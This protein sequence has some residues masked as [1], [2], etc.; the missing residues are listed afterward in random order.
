VSGKDITVHAGITLDHVTGEATCRGAYDPDAF[1]GRKRDNEEWKQRFFLV[2]N[3]HLDSATL[4][5]KEKFQDITVSQFFAT[6]GDPEVLQ[7]PGLMAEFCGGKVYGPMRFEF[8]P[9]VRYSTK[10]TASD[11]DVRE[12]ARLN[13]DQPDD[14]SGKATVRLYLDGKG[15]DPENIKGKGILEVPNAKLYNLPPFVGLLKFLGLRLPD[16]TAF[17]EAYAAFDIERGRIQFTQMR[18]LGDAFSLE[19]K[20]DMKLD[21][22]DLDMEFNVGWARMAQALPGFSYLQTALSKQLFKLKVRGEVGKVSYTKEPIPVI[23]D[24]LKGLF[25]R[26]P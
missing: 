21:G 1:D 5:K 16:R 4:F 6:N 23:L 25:K 2:G 17:D 8:G 14:V 22:S 9:V 13:F 7:V 3:L 26:D 24:P 18:V 20:G 10:L 11:I 12:F 19:G 15:S